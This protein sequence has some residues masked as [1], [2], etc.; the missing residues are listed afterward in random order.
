M[1]YTSHFDDSGFLEF[2]TL[3]RQQSF[4]FSLNSFPS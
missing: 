1:I 3:L 2:C 4:N